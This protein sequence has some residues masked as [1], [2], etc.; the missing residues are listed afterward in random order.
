MAL[1]NSDARITMFSDLALSRAEAEGESWVATVDRIIAELPEHVY[2]SFD[3]DGLDP[4]LCPRTGTPVPGGLSWRQ[5]LVLLSRLSAQRKV[6]GFDL[7]EV[8]VPS[9]DGSDEWD[10]NVGA[11]LLYK[12][13]GCAVRSGSAR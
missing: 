1:V 11:R 6:V 9:E 3:I 5:A 8:G 4:A 7:C 10:A 13:C 2:V 12:L